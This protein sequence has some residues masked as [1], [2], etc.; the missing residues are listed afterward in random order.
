M[1][2]VPP[3]LRGK[4]GSSGGPETSD[5]RPETDFRRTNSSS[6]FNRSG[7]NAQFPSSGS[8]DNLADYGRGVPRS[9]SFARSD[10]AGSYSDLS[11]AGRREA[12]E[13]VFA[14]W[15]PSER[16]QALTDEQILEIRQRLNVQVTDD[17][18]M[19]MTVAPIESFKDMVSVRPHGCCLMQITPGYIVLHNLI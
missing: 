16:V 9:G 5:S 4:G 1:S 11:R 2:Y 10:R 8:R 14:P 7:S 17:P 13:T 6:S 19:P 12:V 18:D 15:K 3:H